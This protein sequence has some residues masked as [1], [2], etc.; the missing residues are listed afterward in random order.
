MRRHLA[1]R[2]RRKRQLSEVASPGVTGDASMAGT[3]RVSRA[4][5]GGRLA[6]HYREAEGVSIGADRR[7]LGSLLADGEGVLLRPIVRYQTTYRYPQQ[8]QFWAL[9]GH[10]RTRICKLKVGCHASA[11]GEI[12]QPPTRGVI[13]PGPCLRLSTSI[14]ADASGVS[15]C[16][17]RTSSRGTI[18]TR[19]STKTPIE[20][21]SVTRCDGRGVNRGIGSGSRASPG[22]RSGAALPR[23][24]G[25]LDQADRRPSRSLSGDGQGVLLRPV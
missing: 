1:R 8:R 24:R 16:A 6:R 20:R 13:T 15:D 2:R 5:S 18:R 22:G 25:P 21:G 7:S 3:A 4:S 19:T 11:P 14:T 9:A 23:G 10:A 12:R 17:G